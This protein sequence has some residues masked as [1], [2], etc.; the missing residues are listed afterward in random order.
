MKLVEHENVENG[1]RLSERFIGSFPNRVNLVMYTREAYTAAYG[2]YHPAFLGL[3]VIPTDDGV[4]LPKVEGRLGPLQYY[5]IKL[6]GKR[7]YQGVGTTVFP[8]MSSSTPKISHDIGFRS[9]AYDMFA[10]GVPV[11]LG[12]GKITGLV[13]SLMFS[14][15]GT[16]TDKNLVRDEEKMNQLD[17][18]RIIYG[19][20]FGFLK[21]AL[22]KLEG[23]RRVDPHDGEFSFLE[24]AL[25][26]EP[27]T[28]TLERKI[29]NL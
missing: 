13:R 19:D 6:A 1:L 17:E 4:V 7:R 18:M 9:Q 10:S 8:D 11:Y 25:N 12:N 20:R 5:N 14:L 27:S 26:Q 22:N 2:G 23:L 28:Q 15:D 29:Q 3:C 24:R 21:T 16:N